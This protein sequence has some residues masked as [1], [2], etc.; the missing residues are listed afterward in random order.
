M[1]KIKYLAIIPA[2]KNSK[3]IKNKNLFKINNKQLIKYSI[4]ASTKVK[5][6]NKIVVSSDDKRILK[7]A[8]KY[9]ITALGRSKK[10][11]KDTTSTEEVI[12]QTYKELT[13]NKILKIENIILLQP[14]SPLRNAKHIKECINL[15]ETKKYDS[16][17]SS[18]RKKEFIWLDKNNKLKSISYN[19]KKRNR[20]QKMNEL[21]FENGAIFI[22][23]VKGFLLSKNR[24]F[25]KIG[26][27]NMSKNKSIDIDNLEDIK[28]IEKI[29]N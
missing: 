12:L 20:T 7:I 26:T 22:F 17:F 18:Y 4:E 28:L 15:Y 6:I 10:I 1:Q 3:R 9:K 14:T 23:S 25:G 16:I 27:Y 24:L 2:R 29:L 8:R 21:I 5:K 11:S 19:F 13:K